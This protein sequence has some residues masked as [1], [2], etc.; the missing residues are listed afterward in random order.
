MVTRSDDVE[1]TARPE[2]WHG[3]DCA[4]SE[5]M[6]IVCRLK[7]RPKMSLR[8]QEKVA[9]PVSSEHALLKKAETYG[10]FCF[11][12]SLQEDHRIVNET[13]I[14]FGAFL[15]HLLPA[16]SFRV[17]RV[18]IVILMMSSVSLNMPSDLWQRYPL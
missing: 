4:A 14:P 2:H 10:C 16:H 18:C 12:D 11:R 15:N 6:Q 9:S 1:S 17:S 3:K 5:Q 7:L 13:S 8:R